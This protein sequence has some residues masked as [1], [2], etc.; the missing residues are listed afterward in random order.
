MIS[1][2]AFPFLAATIGKS[3]QNALVSYARILCSQST[4]RRPFSTQQ[5]G[6]PYSE[7]SIGELAQASSAPR[8]QVMLVRLRSDSSRLT[9]TFHSPILPSGYTA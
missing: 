3:P 8:V 9:R 4:F 2:S 6:T 5:Q 7:L 1:M